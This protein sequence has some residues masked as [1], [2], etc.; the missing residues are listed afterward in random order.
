MPLS[1]T[2]YWAV[3]MKLTLDCQLFQIT[4][5]PDFMQIQQMVQLLIT[6]HWWTGVQLWSSHNVLLFSIRK[7]VLITYDLPIPGI[8]FQMSAVSWSLPVLVLICSRFYTKLLQISANY[9]SWLK[10][11]FLLLLPVIS[12]CNLPWLTRFAYKTTE[13]LCSYKYMVCGWSVFCYLVISSGIF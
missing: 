10:P 11:L 3:C 5:I 4:S 12:C 8:Q 7:T 2:C 1:K 13:V 6:G 9:K